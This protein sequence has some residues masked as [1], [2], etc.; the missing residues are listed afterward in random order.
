MAEKRIVSAVGYFAGIFLNL[1]A[2]LKLLKKSGNCFSQ[3]LPTDLKKRLDRASY[4]SCLHKIEASDAIFLGPLSHNE[5]YY[6][7]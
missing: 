3:K 5:A 1:R 7:P 2:W 6:M 4:C